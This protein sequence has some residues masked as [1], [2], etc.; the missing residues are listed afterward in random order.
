MVTVT[1]WRSNVICHST[2]R[3]GFLFDLQTIHYYLLWM[4]IYYWQEC[5][6]IASGSATKFLP[7]L[8]VTARSC[9]FKVNVMLQVQGCS[10]L[11]LFNE[12]SEIVSLR[13]SNL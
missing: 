8:S 9:K 12:F 10:R 3:A 7:L 11:L 13:A 5:S 4:W 6:V 2:V 1:T